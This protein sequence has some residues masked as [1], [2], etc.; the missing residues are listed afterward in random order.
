MSTLLKNTPSTG[1]FVVAQSKNFKDTYQYEPLKDGEIRLFEIIQTFTGHWLKSPDIK[2]SLKMRTT[3]LS[4]ISDKY[5][6]MSYVWGD[7]TKKCGIDVTSSGPNG[8]IVTGNLQINLNLLHTLQQAHKMSEHSRFRRQSRLFWADAIC[9]NQA[10][11]EGPFL[12]EREKQVRIMHQI[13]S[14]ASQVI[15]DL[16]PGD[17]YTTTVMEMTHKLDRAHAR[18]TEKQQRLEMGDLTR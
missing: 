16:G 11:N 4:E 13:Y 7:E 15:V 17:E 14:S 6:A 5:S 3:K 8:E 2:L 9:I 1:P 12:Q 10:G 18:H